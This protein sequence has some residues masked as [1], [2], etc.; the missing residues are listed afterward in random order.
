MYFGITGTNVRL[1][2]SLHMVPAARPEMP[3]FVERAYDWCEQ[4]GLEHAIDFAL[5]SLM[6]LPQGETLE[7]KMPA[8]LFARIKAV[9]PDDHPRGALRNQSL[10]VVVFG[11]AL[12]NIKTVDGVDPIFTAR[13]K[14]QEKPIKYLETADDWARLSGSVKDQEY[15]ELIGKIL[16]MPGRSERIA[17][18]L[19]DAWSNYDTNRVTSILP[20]TTMALQPA[21]RSVMMDQRNAEWMPKILEATKE[22]H[23]ILIA[24][25]ALHLVGEKGLLKLLH[26]Q[27]HETSLIL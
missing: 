6:S 2:G 1:L 4:I 15:L 5:L 13:A 17:R 20:K 23:K 18:E 16:A 22:P 19:H 25:G 27:G 14:A 12:L 10:W 21:I 26:A 9:W 24:V 3:G 7:K 11:L 8:E